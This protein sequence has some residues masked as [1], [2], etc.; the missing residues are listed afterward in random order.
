MEKEN[1][2]VKRNYVK[3][4]NIKKQLTKNNEIVNQ[5]NKDEFDKLFVVSFN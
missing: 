4:G 5:N 2:T 1:K 3:K